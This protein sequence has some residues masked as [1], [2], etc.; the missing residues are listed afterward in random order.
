MGTIARLSKEEFI[1]WPWV[2]KQLRSLS[3]SVINQID[4]MDT[5]NADRKII[6]ISA[7]SCRIFSV[8]KGIRHKR[9]E[10]CNFVSKL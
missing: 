9:G 7:I 10:K 3:V 8:H 5:S 4:A 2:L 6:I 1:S